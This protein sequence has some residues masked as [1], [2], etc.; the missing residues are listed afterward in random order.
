MSSLPLQLDKTLTA[1]RLLQ[2]ENTLGAA[3]DG[4]EAFKSKLKFQIQHE[5]FRSDRK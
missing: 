1:M 2:L 3:A 5:V 4:S